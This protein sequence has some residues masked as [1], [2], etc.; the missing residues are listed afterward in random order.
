M[1]NHNI[2]AIKPPLVSVVMPVYNVQDYLAESV[3]S[4]LAQS[5][6]DFE[7]I[8]VDDGSTDASN[9]MAQMFALKDKRIRLVKQ[10]NRGLAGARNTGIYESVGEYVAFLDSDDLWHTDKLQQH[11]EF[12]KSRPNV[13]VSYS[14]SEFIDDQ[15]ESIGLYQSPKISGICKVKKADGRVNFFDETLRQSEDIECWVR[16]ISTTNWK[17]AGIDEA[18]TYYRVNDSGLSANTTAQLTSWKLAI[19]KMRI[20]APTLVKRYGSLAKAYQYRYLARRAVR[21]IDTKNAIKM[22]AMSLYEAPSIL[23][24]EPVRTLQTL[25]ATV[26]LAIMPTGIYK[27]IESLAIRFSNRPT[28]FSSNA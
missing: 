12:M 4:V 2:S 16:I 18:L 25:G 26:C 8:L 10:T 21:S 23:V 1:F 14:S 17:F 11:I 6:T 9:L 28:I 19:S 13:G 22:I 15:G 24:R 20:Y 7:L 27:S 5:F 3:E